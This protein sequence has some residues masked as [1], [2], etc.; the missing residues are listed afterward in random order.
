M[1]ISTTTFFVIFR[2]RFVSDAAEFKE[3][4]SLGWPT[5]EKGH[6]KAKFLTPRVPDEIMTSLSTLIIISPAGES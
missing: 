3:L 4:W 2:L 1:L 5:L 6:R